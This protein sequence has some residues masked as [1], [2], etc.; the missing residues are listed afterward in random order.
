MFFCSMPARSTAREMV[1]AARCHALPLLQI[2]PDKAHVC[3]PCLLYT[4]GLAAG[5]NEEKALRGVERFAVYLLI[6]LDH[7]RAVV[8]VLDGLT[9]AA[10]LDD[11]S[12]VEKACGNVAVAEKDAVDIPLGILQIHAGQILARVETQAHLSLIHI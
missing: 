8:V 7:L 10:G 1:Q 9:V 2:A 12:A 5:R 4:S 3:K 6:A 11:V